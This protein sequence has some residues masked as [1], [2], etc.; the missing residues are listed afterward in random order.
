MNAIKAGIAVWKT[1]CPIG[2]LRALAWSCS[3]GT[4]SFGAGVEVFCDFVVASLLGLDDLDFVAGVEAFVLDANE[5]GRS[6][7]VLSILY[8]EK[9]IRVYESSETSTRC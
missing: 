7:D 3:H 9:T 4:S 6:A 5:S 8:S 1:F 2:Q